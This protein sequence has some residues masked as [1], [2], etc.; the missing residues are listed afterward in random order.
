MLTETRDVCGIPLWLM[1]EYLVEMGGAPVKDGLVRGDGWSVQLTKIAP[2]QVGS[3][4][5]GQIRVE[6]RGD[7][8]GLAKLKEMIEPKLLRAGG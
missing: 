4:C 2:R 7:A 3:L 6:M 8:A 1:Q 5:V